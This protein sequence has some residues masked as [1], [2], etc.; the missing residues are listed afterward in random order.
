[1]KHR[2]KGFYWVEWTHFADAQLVARKPGPLMGEWDGRYWWFTRM[3]AYCFD[4]EVRVLSERLQP[5]TSEKPILLGAD[6]AA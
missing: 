4:C 3:H 1:M 6:L 5:P 2:D